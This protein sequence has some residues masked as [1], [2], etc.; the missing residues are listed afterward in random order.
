LRDR[1]RELVW[2]T[3]I[4]DAVLMSSAYLI[5]WFFYLLRHD[6]DSQPS[7]AGL[8]SLV[9]IVCLTT[10][11]LYL[12]HVY[13]SLQFKTLGK[14]LAETLIAVTQAFGIV[15][16]LIFVYKLNTIS[17]EFVLVYFS[18]T[19]LAVLLR[20]S[21]QK[22]LAAAFIGNGKFHKAMLIV[23]ANEVSRRFARMLDAYKGL[24]FKVAGILATKDS[25]ER[26]WAVRRQ[27][28][29]IIGTF[30]DL[31]SVLKTTVVDEVVF[32]CTEK[33]MP[34]E[35]LKECLFICE[36]Y[37][38]KTAMLSKFSNT[39]YHDMK[40]DNLG[41]LNLISYVPR[42][43]SLRARLAKRAIDTAFSGLALLALSPVMAAIAAAIKLDSPGPVFF[44]QKR[45]GLNG[46][47]ISLL[48]FRSMCIDAEKRKNDLLDKNE[49]QGPVFKIK[50]DPRITR[51]GRFMR[52]YSMDELPQLI[53][54][55]RGDMSL[56]GPRPLPLSEVERLQRWQRRRLSVKPGIT[57]LWQV[58]GRNNIGFEDWMKLDLE[59]IDNWSLQMD[60]QLLF[61]TFAEVI[62][63]TG[64]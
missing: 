39:R 50:R 1:V 15:V 33:E 47:V 34:W 51:V 6:I 63:G 23:G 64:M 46:R 31:D 17:R 7:G 29:P 54:V 26:G 28:A 45:C 42:N 49:V 4:A 9:F 53:N 52:K 2:F 38:V 25:D 62:K 16:S 12:N 11:C 44:R 18:C 27:E 36:E 30:E 8:L 10:F 57:C 59:Y 55:L 48:K 40:L 32:A 24:G 60:F 14:I 3:V 21:L 43:S 61:R 37:G 20:R 35:V 41:R 19:F 13:E 58:S 56:V 5:A 22:R